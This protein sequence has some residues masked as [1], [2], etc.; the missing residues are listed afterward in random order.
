MA[1]GPGSQLQHYRIV[2]KLGEG[3]M[4]VV[5]RATDTTLDREVAI[6]VLPEV[7]ADDDERAQRFEREAKLL[8]SL[9][10]PNI[11]AIHGLHRVE[12]THFLAMELV[13]GEDL[14]QRLTR[15]ALSVD[16]T[17]DVA[18]QI[19]EALEAAHEGGV[20]HR[21]LKPANVKLGPDGKIK[22]LDFGLAKAMSPETS[23]GGSDPSLSP[24]LTS[25]NTQAGMILG[26][27]AYM[28][29]EQARGRPVDRRTD[30]WSF[31][32]L[33]YECLTGVQLFGGE[34]ISDS[35]AAVLRKD[36]DWELLPTG[37]PTSIKKMLKRCLTRDPRKRLQDAGDA[38]VELES[39][40][41]EPEE[42]AALAASAP[43]ETAAPKEPAMQW[44]PWALVT[45]AVLVAGWFA[46]SGRGPST[47]DPA[48]SKLTIPVPGPTEF[49]D[50]AASPPAISPDGRFVVY[51]VEEPTGETRLWL[52]PLD[53][54]E[55]R[56]IAGTEGAAYAFWSPDSRH[57]A[58]FRGGKL[59]RIEIESGREQ[60][61]GGEG[62]TYPRGASWNASDQIVFAPNSNTGIH[63]IAAGG[64]EARQITTPDPDIPDS[65][66]RWPYFLPD[67]ERFLFTLWTNDLESQQ[68]HGG[69]YISSL[70][71]D[72]PRR[73]V[74]DASSSA[75]SSS[76]HIL[77][78]RGDNLVAIPFDAGRGEVTGEAAVI[79]SD[80][81]RNRANG[82]A[83][84][85][86]S[87]DQTLIY[88]TGQSMLPSALSWYDRDGNRT[89][90]AGDPAPFLNFRLS[91]DSKRAAVS[92]PGPT[93][94]G[95]I[96]VQDLARGVRTRL[97]QSQAQFDNP[98]WSGDGLRILYGSQERGA[99]DL[100]SRLADGSGDEETML[101]DGM[102][103]ILYDW[104]LDGRWV[105]YWPLG[106]G[107]G[108]PDV[109]I[110]SVE[111][112][113][114][115]SLIDGEP[116]YEDARFSPDA[117]WLT[118]VS[119]D[120]GRRE[121]YAHAFGGAGAAGGARLQVSTA[122]GERPHW[123]RDGREIIYVDPQR[124]LMAVAVE[125]TGGTLTL[126]QPQEL[127]TFEQAI[128][129]GDVTGDHRRFLVATREEV[130]SDPLRVILNWPADL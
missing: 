123:R 121:V 53:D 68:K 76:G 4:G 1:V 38:R 40:I 18:R 47:T 72:E 59:R 105:A 86:T 52:R 92:L 122:G 60:A 31:G 100:V 128:Q 49:G 7:F 83:A 112:Q 73:L 114:S 118:Y 119:D 90:V 109:W 103:K 23:S 11:A 62:S 102:D 5:W 14:A 35:L 61:I 101:I 32:C 46:M 6:K 36:P 25:A 129:A 24:T 55:T 99:M 8:A 3:G 33:L 108:T 19:A 113:T 45:A 58:F 82:H 96:W 17:L 12:G 50:L 110:Y 91:P 107:Q 80:V 63:V 2:D 44:L 85:T 69:I 51:G 98:A 78:V 70:A 79:A 93:G 89:P 117:R 21:D 22:V 20:V 43:G 77:V 16:T 10:H 125:E 126:G 13:E 65:S 28:S 115:Q 26:T 27:A 54:F 127:F 39:A 74:P 87:N 81:L 124:R 41:E 116:T 71:G 94:D 97:L 34:T 88:A 84:F 30:L 29:P 48:A 130:Q 75:Y 120:S 111:D 106:S 37:T 104:S 57:V 95:E 56:P 67:G 64:G 9:N 15:G 66:H 42:E